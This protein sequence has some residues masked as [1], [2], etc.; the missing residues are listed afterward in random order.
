MKKN[1][2]DTRT[3]AEIGIF[4]ALGYVADLLQGSVTSGLFPNGGSFGFAMVAIFIIAFRR[5]CLPAVLTGL[6]MGL[7]DLMDGFTSISDTWYKV[8][9]QVALD[10][11][12]AYPL[13]GLAGLFSGLIGKQ[14]QPK[15]KAIYIGVACF[16]GSFAKF[17]AH[18]LSGVLFWP[19]GS[20]T[21]ASIAYSITYNGSYMLP[22]F[23]ICAI[24]MILVS[25]KQPQLF[26]ATYGE[27]K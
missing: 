14:K 21:G 1:K 22:S 19:N 27:E 25:L 11:W 15:L 5:G 2:F 17:I 3:M 9:A 12:I 16:V 26:D 20:S 10:Y 6:I 23:V 8:F 24:I 7:L 13:V 18:F 4:A